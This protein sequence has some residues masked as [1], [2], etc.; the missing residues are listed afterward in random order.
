M[1][2][3]WRIG[4]EIEI[5]KTNEKYNHLFWATTILIN[6]L[7]KDYLNFTY[8]IIGNQIGDVVNYI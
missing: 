2:V 1:R 3:E 5:K 6:F 8:I 7:H 4:V